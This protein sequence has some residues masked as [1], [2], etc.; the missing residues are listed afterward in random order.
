M[1]EEETKTKKS[2]RKSVDM[3]IGAVDDADPEQ[4]GALTESLKP[5]AC[6]KSH[7]S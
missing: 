5:F 3:V 2:S 6:S 4:V 1:P 7:V